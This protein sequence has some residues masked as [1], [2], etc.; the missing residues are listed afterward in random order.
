M[1]STNKIKSVS[2]GLILVLTTIIFLGVILFR[3]IDQNNKNEKLVN[4][5]YDVLATSKNLQSNITDAETALRGYI[6]TDNFKFLEPLHNSKKQKDS[7]TT[8]L[9][10]LISDNPH[11]IKEVAKLKG[12]ITKKYDHINQNLIIRKNEGQKAAFDFIN[13]GHGRILMDSIRNS[14]NHI[15]KEENK[16]L[17]Q[18]VLNSQLSNRTVK[19]ILLIGIWSIIVIFIIVFNSLF[20][21]LR[22]LRRKEEQLFI[23]NEWYNQTLISMDDAVITIDNQGKITM[24]NEAAT[25][26]TGWKNK[27]AVGKNINDVVTLINSKT[28]NKIDNPSLIVLIN[29]APISLNEDIVLIRKDGR[30]LYVEDNAAPIHNK[31]G[32]VIGAVIIL[33]D[34]HERIL[35]EEERNMIYTISADMIGILG[36]EGVFKKV[37]PAFENILGYSEQELL[38]TSFFNFIHKEDVEQTKEEFI[39]LSNG[40]PTLNYACRVV[41]KNDNIKWLEWNVIPMGEIFYANARNITERKKAAD[42]IE[43]SR[44]KFY[45]I[46]EVNPIAIAITSCKEGRFKYV[47]DAFCQMSGYPKEMLIDNLAGDFKMMTHENRDEKVKDLEA[48]N[49]QAKN[50]EG[51]FKKSDDSFIDVIFYV[52]T[53]DIEGELCHL[54]SLI[55]ITHKKKLEENITKLNQTLENRVKERTEELVKQKKFTDNL[56]NKIPTE[57]AV[58]DKNRRYLYVNPE[59]VENEEL[60]LWIIGKSDYDYCEFLGIDTTLADKRS[61]AFDKI[62]NN[63][64][65]NWIDEIQIQDGIV[66][67]MLRMLHPIENDDK[68]ILTG[69]DIT[70]IKL[71]EKEHEEYTNNL[72]QMMFMTS[73]QVRLPVSHILGLSSLLHEEL[74]QADLTEI[75]KHF[76]NSVDSLDKFTHELTDFIHDLKEKT[77][78]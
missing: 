22:R 32:L 48:K 33:R 65:V 63:E 25:I 59:C 16:L 42:I 30:K 23:Q 17:H 43:A 54:S 2:F 67:Y 70:H 18:R 26:I 52:E 61:E 3:S 7:L 13:E 72:E 36:C 62:K 75:I 60:R 45:K 40:T 74:S 27:E 8:K 49:G 53:I 55:D 56:L 10:N 37:N 66:K 5:T 21:Q 29:N 69:Y 19:N 58:Y 47:N 4:H 24:L 71:A 64:D 78:K 68:Y 46:L 76:K 12:F 1:H 77:G 41:C 28:G 51:S 57:I 14:F 38:S 9:S 50:I 15:D 35:A 34:I 39:N 44:K 6:I 20:N 11:Q 73:H 31:K